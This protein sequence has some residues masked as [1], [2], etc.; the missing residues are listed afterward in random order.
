MFGLFRKK[1][2]K[3]RLQ[4]RYYKL[5]E[6]AYKLSKVNRAESDLKLA[7]ADELMKRIELLP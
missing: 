5:L 2:E 1:T 6:D 3:E 4:S 7:Q